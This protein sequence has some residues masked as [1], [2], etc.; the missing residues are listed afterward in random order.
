MVA[1][2]W[3]MKAFWNKCMWTLPRNTNTVHV[4]GVRVSISSC[5]VQQR[6]GPVDVL[7][8]QFTPVW[9]VSS[10]VHT[11][12]L[13]GGLYH[14][15]LAFEKGTLKRLIQVGTVS[16]NLS[17]PSTTLKTFTAVLAVVKSTRRWGLLLTESCPFLSSSKHSPVWNY[18]ER[19][20][21]FLLLEPCVDTVFGH[22]YILPEERH[23]TVNLKTHER[24]LRSLQ[25][26]WCWIQSGAVG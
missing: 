18:W 20:R 15:S 10:P 13:P 5:W 25:E 11:T 22:Q 16:L 17:A 9:C 26:C 6:S 3:L 19:L 7:H 4:R 8:L 24:L 12:A 2:G 23:P 14:Y 1:F 21:P